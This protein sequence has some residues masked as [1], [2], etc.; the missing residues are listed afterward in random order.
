MSCSSSLL[1][2]LVCVCVCV[3]FLSNPE[4][5]HRLGSGRNHLRCCAHISFNITY[6]LNLNCSLCLCLVALCRARNTRS[7]LPLLFSVYPR[8]LCLHEVWAPSPHF[9]ISWFKSPVVLPHFYASVRISAT[10]Y[11]YNILFKGL[12]SIH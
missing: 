7:S 4:L 8:F 11:K 6:L 10:M 1:I 9:P 2:L 3:W 5:Y 12:R